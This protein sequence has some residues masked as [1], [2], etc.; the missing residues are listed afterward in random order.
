MSSQLDSQL[1]PHPDLHRAL[2]LAAG[3]GESAASQPAADLDRART[4][5]RN[6]RRRRFRYAVSG[7]TSATV[8]AVLVAGVVGRDDVPAPSPGDHPAVVSGAVVLVAGP[9][10]VGAY[11]FEQ[12]PQG[13]AVQG[14]RPTAL[15]IAPT[16]GSVSDDPDDF[17][18]KLVVMLDRERMYGYS[19]EQ[20]GRTFHV[21]RGEGYTTVSVRTR[22]D[23]PDGVVRIQYPDDAGW[24]TAQMLDF[25]AGVR[26]TPEAEP[27]FG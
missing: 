25:L 17:Q 10:D 9:L 27:G 14:Q 23:E 6:R 4:A 2:A 26:V 11:V 21:R 13:W 15:T 22:A 20:D 8:V 24:A 12:V 18:G 1:D 16:D 3:P 19:V 7:L 5:V